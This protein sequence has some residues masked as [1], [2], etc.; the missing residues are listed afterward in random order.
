LSTCHDIIY[1]GGDKNLRMFQESCEALCV[2][3]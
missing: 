2:E 3:T 1:R